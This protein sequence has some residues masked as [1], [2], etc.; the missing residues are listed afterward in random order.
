MLFAVFLSGMPV[1]AILQIPVM[2]V[3]GG[4]IAVKMLDALMNR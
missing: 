4:W 2:V 1:V 3:S